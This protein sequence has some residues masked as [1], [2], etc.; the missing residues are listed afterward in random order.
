ML[1][2]AIMAAMGAAT[3]EQLLTPLIA[4]PARSAILL[5]VDGT[6]APIV[7]EATAA[8][9]PQPTREVLRKVAD[10]YGL[11]ACVT[12]RQ[13]LRALEMVGL[14]N[15]VYFGNHG[16]ELLRPGSSAVEV[17]PDAA[18]W[19]DRVQEFT[20]TAF[21]E[22][23]LARLGVTTEDKGPIVGLHWRGADDDGAA[24]EAIR[25]LASEAQRRGLGVHWAKKILEVRPPV[26]FSKGSAVRQ[27]LAEASIETAL[28]AGDDLTDIHAFEALDEAVA[29]G[30]IARAIKIG[31]DS[32]EAPAALAPAADVMLA[33]T[34]AVVEMLELLVAG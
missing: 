14:D 2:P 30:V 28:F 5:D 7:T 21:S 31:V 9:V 4:A 16:S 33:G 32:D 29:D 8:T 17:A 3:L 11:V 1:P 15:I 19:Q 6:L 25:G 20:T 26:H 22:F 34:E 24:E 23:D 13:P 12:G 10:R 18:A 27:L